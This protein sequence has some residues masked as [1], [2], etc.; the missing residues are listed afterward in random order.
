MVPVTISS[1]D[2]R[3]EQSGLT[4]QWTTAMEKAN[5]GFN[6][7]G[8]IE[9]NWVKLNEQMI[10]SRVV[11]AE[12][13]QTY[14]A[15]FP[16]AVAN[17]ILVEDIDIT[18]RG[19]R[20]G[21]FVVG[22]KHGAEPHLKRVDLAAIQRE[23]DRAKL[24]D[25][26]LM[27]AG[28]SATSARLAVTESGIQ[29]VG[30]ADLAGAGVN[31]NGVPLAKIGIADNG[32]AVS[33]TIDDANKNGVFDTGDAIEFVGEV[34]KTLYSKANVY[35]LTSNGDKVAVAESR[36][37]DSK[38]GVINTYQASYKAYPDNEYN[39]SAPVGLIPWHDALLI[40]PYGPT[41]LSRTFDLPD[42]NASSATTSATLT[43]DLWGL[44]DLS[45][46]NDHHVLV[47]LNGGTAVADTVFDGLTAKQLKVPV[48][49]GKLK[50][51]A[52]TLELS[53]PFDSGYLFDFVGLDGFRLD[54]PAFAQAKNGLWSG[55]LPAGSLALEVSKLSDCANLRAWARQGNQTYQP[56]ALPTVNSGGDC[57][58]VLPAHRNQP[59]RYWL[60]TTGSTQKPSVQLG[61]PEKTKRAARKTEYLIISHP[62]FAGSLTELNGLHG[63]QT[64][65]VSTDAIY[66]AYS[67]HQRDAD[68]IQTFIKES[69]REGGK[70]RYVLIVGGD[71][72]DYF[73][74]YG[75]EPLAF[76]PTRYAKVGSIINFAPTD[77][78]YGD[79][80][81]DKIPDLAVGRL[82]VR[83]LP[84]LASAIA[85]LKGYAG[86]KAGLMVTGKSDSGSQFAQQHANM[87][88]TLA[89]GGWKLTDLS[90]DDYPD[91]AVARSDL[92][93]GF[94]RGY[95]IVSYLG[96]SDYDYWDFGPLF[97]RND[98]ASLPSGNAQP[99]VVQ[100]GCWNS[101]FVA[102]R[103]ETMAHGLLLTKDKGAA[104][105]IGSSTLT[106]LAAH[107][108]L[109]QRFFK[110]LSKG[111]ITLG[112]ALLKAQREVATQF[113]DL[114]D[115]ILA[116]N[117]LGDPALEL[118]R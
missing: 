28:N 63:L 73:N 36:P 5:A 38:N 9:G 94:G 107:D 17:Q 58:V 113:P 10:P 13:P 91:A 62:L 47:Y 30:F 102:T 7:Y 21:P 111:P 67:D 61:V 66:A 78:L 69:A 23:N 106:E 60:A 14:T 81:G 114:R 84:E 77:V 79:I 50:T 44:S 33:R 70:L 51:A 49:I 85:K 75:A 80:D 109:G 31:L 53:L 15:S 76:V 74:I 56:S 29:R 68:A 1:V 42:L 40:A 97:H 101:Y 86:G 108:A 43:V 59:L 55:D 96:H 12:E 57:S 45:G 22:Q 4:V 20:H 89:T 83:T 18:G 71:N 115:D 118:G 35:V 26:T 34:E 100:W 3:Q 54:Y 52:N 72:Y 110:N 24:A 27:A 105:V 25:R 112:D 82:I 116:M 46:S 87:S 64:E 39:A 16:Q 92:L 8:N 6:I 88:A 11:N 117:L 48:D 65:V 99:V 103:F 41:T 19:Q 90:V 2:S 37:L 95:G 98:V 93:A 104:S 32:R